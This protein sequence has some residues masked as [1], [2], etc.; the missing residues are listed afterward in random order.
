MHELAPRQRDVIDFI[1]ATIEQRGFPPTYRE[2]GDALGISSTN[3]VADHVK[4]L[5]R[6]GY[7]IKAES[8][9]ARGIRLTEKAGPI[10]RGGTMS[11]PLVGTV[12]AGVP[13]LAVE[14]YERT[15]HFDRDL[16]GGTGSFFSLEVRGDSMIEEGIFEGDYLIVRQQSTASNGDI[17]VA[18]VGDE[19]TVKFYFREGSRIR[20]QPAHPTMPPIYI[21]P[22]EQGVIQGVVVGIFR[23]YSV[24]P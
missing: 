9:A 5:V 4:A 20:L 14:N 13:V 16:I 22:E 19:A 6:K 8:G 15:F 11:I 23:R 7:L 2:I 18:L 10:E 12:A 21:Q 17:V 1:S 3:G 24:S